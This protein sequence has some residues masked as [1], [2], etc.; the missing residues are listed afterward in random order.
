M[1]GFG[2][3][4]KCSEWELFI[5]KS[6]EKSL[7][8]LG[9]Y[10][11]GRLFVQLLFLLDAFAVAYYTS[12]FYPGYLTADSL[13]IL[14]QG[15]G[16][17]PLS[18]WHPPFVTILWGGLQGVF[19]SAGGIWMIQIVLL[20]C[21]THFF[22]IGL[23]KPVVSLLSYLLV[24]FFPPV[25]TNMAALWKDC[26]AVIF[27]LF[28]AG[29]AVRAIRTNSLVQAHV[30][31]LFF[32]LASLT[33]VDYLIVAAPIAFGALALCDE[34][35]NRTV[36]YRN[37]AARRVLVYMLAV[38]FASHLLG[39]MVEKRLNPWVTVAIWDIGGVKNSLGGGG[40]VLGYNCATS[41]SLTF[42]E[43]RLFEA[44]L[45]EEP[46]RMDARREAREIKRSWVE[47]V[48]SSPGAYLSHRLCVARTFFGFAPE[49]HYP[50]PPPVFSD[51]AMTQSAQRSALN[52][53]LYWF[54]DAN[55]NGLM[56]R[57]CFYLGLSLLVVVLAYAGRII[58]PIQLMVGLS[59]WMSAARVLVLPAADFRYGLW[60]VVGTIA[61]VALVADALMVRCVGERHDRDFDR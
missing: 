58:E 13:Y 11:A 5:R 27:T 1:A 15:V 39:G 16:D 50:Y 33:R 49:V 45:P 20:V 4:K 19:K 47:S 28:C 18:N 24:L 61:L 3:L 23:R 37:P 42:G 29:F 48:V 9:S 59:I 40:S 10:A 12:A 60:I 38:L 25:F 30:A 43:H 51:S 32:V 17:Q 54:Y 56:F 57:Y 44:N 41:D 36:W 53:D 31:A 34:H 2:G 26:W 14:A 22:A 55:S 21:A 35:R 46:L 52:R 8:F 6:F 7:A